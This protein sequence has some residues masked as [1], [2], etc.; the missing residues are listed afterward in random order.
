M[1][2]GE[3]GDFRQFCSLDFKSADVV[4]G[5]THLVGIVH[6]VQ[7]VSFT[8]IAFSASLH[9]VW[10]NVLCVLVTSRSSLPFQCPIK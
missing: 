2:G 3:A 8:L 9:A 6:C 1:F 5:E 10:W 4:I 7:S